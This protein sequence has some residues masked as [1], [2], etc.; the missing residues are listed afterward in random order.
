VVEDVFEFV[1]QAE[2]LAAAAV[3]GVEEDEP[4]PVRPLHGGVSLGR[5]DPL[6]LDAWQLGDDLFTDWGFGLAAQPPQPV[7]LSFGHPQRFGG[8]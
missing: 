3:G 1:G 6:D 2:P 7:G 8:G 5:G 4:A